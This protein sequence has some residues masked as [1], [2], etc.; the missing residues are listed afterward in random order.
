M[1]MASAVNSGSPV[2]L[3]GR[4]SVCSS[5]MLT[6]WRASARWGAQ[7]PNAADFKII[8][9]EVL[10]E[11]REFTDGRIVILTRR[12]TWHLDDSIAT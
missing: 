10:E 9:V 7:A 1:T 8:L 4:T 6:R 12:G 11:F 3:P 2:M 5:S